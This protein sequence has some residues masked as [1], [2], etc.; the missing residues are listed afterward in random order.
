MRADFAEL[1]NSEGSLAAYSK[2]MEDASL[3]AAKYKEAIEALRHENEGLQQQVEKGE[4][5]SDVAQS[6]I[7]RNIN[8]IERYK[9]QISNL[10][11][12]MAA[13]RE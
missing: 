9:V 12:S 7:V 8:T 5:N 13:D 4:K 11:H 1:R 2:R 10:E 6:R 3:T